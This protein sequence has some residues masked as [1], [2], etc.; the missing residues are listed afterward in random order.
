[1]AYPY[2]ALQII[3]HAK[4]RYQELTHDDALIYLQEVHDKLTKEMRLTD[5]SQVFA[6]VAGQALYTLGSTVMKVWAVELAFAL[7]R[8]RALEQV[9]QRQEEID[10]PGFRTTPTNTPCQV[11]QAPGTAGARQLGFYPVPSTSALVVTAATNATPIVITTSVAHGLADG[12]PVLIDGAVG[13]TA[14][15]GAFYALVTGY[16]PTTFA[17][18]SDSAL[19]LPVA[20]NGVWSSGGVV[21]TTTVPL[22]RAYTTKSTTLVDGTVLPES[23][24]SMDA[25]LHGIWAKHTERRN[26][27][28]YAEHL[29]A[30]Q[31]AKVALRNDVSGVL[32]DVRQ[33]TRPYFV[34]RHQSR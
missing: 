8:P 13:N 10:H 12:N 23:V 20:G 24:R 33:K 17:L 22:I 21:A 1:M 30:E 9:S 26:P 15:N 7:G 16:S 27:T 5:D 2:T 4:K 29:Q 19:T 28:A 18:Y 34:Q 14:A 3:T 32:A 11:Y 25:Y 6:P 31:R